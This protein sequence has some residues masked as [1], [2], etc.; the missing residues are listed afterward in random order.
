[1]AEQEGNLYFVQVGLEVNAFDIL[2]N[3]K[4]FYIPRP[5]E[6]EYISYY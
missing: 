2:Q 6:L 1:M 3:N 4:W 5:T